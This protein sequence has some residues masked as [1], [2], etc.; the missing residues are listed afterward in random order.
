VVKFT[1]ENAPKNNNQSEQQTGSPQIQS[2]RT[3]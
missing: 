1:S 3:G 2:Q